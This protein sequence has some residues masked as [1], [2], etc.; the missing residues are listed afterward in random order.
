MPIIEK[1][2]FSQKT[3]SLVS[4]ATFLGVAVLLFVILFSPRTAEAA[5]FPVGN[6]IGY[7]M[8][9]YG[10]S[11]AKF[12]FEDLADLT[13]TN[14]GETNY[15]LNPARFEYNEIT[16]SWDV[17]G[18]GYNTY[19]CSSGV[20]DS[21]AAHMYVTD[22]NISDYSLAT[23]TTYAVIWASSTNPVATT[24]TDSHIHHYLLFRLDDNGKV[25]KSIASPYV[26][27]F[28]SY[29]ENT[30]FTDLVVTSSSTPGYVTFDVDWYI[31]PDEVNTT[32]SRLNPT[33][34][35]FQIASSSL[36]G[37]GYSIDT[38]TYGYDSMTE[39]YPQYL[40][41]GSYTAKISFTN[42]G[43]SMRLSS[44][45]FHYSHI[46][47]DF[48]LSSGVIVSSSTPTFSSAVTNA[49]WESLGVVPVYDCSITNLDDCFKSVLTWAFV[50]GD[51][52]SEYWINTKD[53]IET[54]AP[55]VYLFTFVDALENFTVV[56]SGD[57]PDVSIYT[58]ALGTTTIFA[59]D[60]AETGLLS[61]VTNVLR[62]ASAAAFYFVGYLTIFYMVR[63]FIRSLT[64]S[65][66]N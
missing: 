24:T 34:I 11:G 26:S 43:C 33:A 42:A 8:E 45:P 1:G 5:T 44:C 9:R 2:M 17:I 6:N 21:H 38:D 46:Y 58:E 47:F 61:E 22:L 54:K 56:G 50:P 51:F 60:M 52:S 18:A 13:C 35:F 4:G 30:R 57:I 12:I 19:T 25:Q 55:F 28:Q 37:F 32:I 31:D 48:T 27:S 29:Y 62:I 65:T 20:Y 40:G 14:E 63:R 10:T 7:T 23:S 39:T 64:N 15:R 49:N 3:I 66:A 53:Y 41:D 16:E 59:N 36:Q